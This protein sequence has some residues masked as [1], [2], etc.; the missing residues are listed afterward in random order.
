MKAQDY[1]KIIMLNQETKKIMCENEIIWE[2][3]WWGKAKNIE[4][5][6]LEFMS[7]ANA[8]FYSNIVLLNNKNI[9]QA[10]VKWN[11]SALRNLVQIDNKIFGLGPAMYISNNG[12]TVGYIASIKQQIDKNNGTNKVNTT[13]KKSDLV[14]VLEMNKTEWLIETYCESMIQFNFWVYNKE[15]GKDLN[16]I[17]NILGL[18]IAVK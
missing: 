16:R 3:K 14:K 2:N 1:E 9:N 6:K 10:Y 13:I 18:F 4:N 15:L 17:N 8:Y 12:T 11:E 5:P 7:H